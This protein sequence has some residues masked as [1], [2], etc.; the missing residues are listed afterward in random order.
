MKKIILAFSIFATFTLTSCNNPLDKKYDEKTFEQ[1]AKEIGES[2]KLDE[3]EAKMLVGYILMAK[4]GGKELTGKSYAEIL[5]TAKDYKAEQQQLAEKARK[6]SEEKRAKLG[7]VLTVALYDK[8]YVKEDYQDYIQYFIVFENK[9]D[10][11]IRAIKG[12]LTITDLFDTEIK[13]ISVVEDNGVL[14]KQTI[15]NTYTSEYN[16][17]LD[18]DKRLAGKEMKDLKALWTPEKI[19]FTDGTTLE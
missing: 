8:G 12:T 14:A 9:T 18:E 5:Q 6:E 1:D 19:I 4:L 17:F 13:S 15:K 11:D 7:A 2:K 16:Q 10:K 3:V